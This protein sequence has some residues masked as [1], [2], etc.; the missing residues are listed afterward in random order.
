MSGI[1]VGIPW[2]CTACC[3]A[4]HP[5]CWCLSPEGSPKLVPCWILAREMG[6]VAVTPGHRVLPLVLPAQLLFQQIW[7]FLLDHA[8]HLLKWPCP[9]D[10][11]CTCSL[12][13]VSPS[14][15]RRCADLGAV[16]G[17]SFP[18]EGLCPVWAL[19][20]SSAP[21]GDLKHCLRVQPCTGLGVMGQTGG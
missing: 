9:C 12:P 3:V 20:E 11:A 17:H 5:E 8:R 16:L 2:K 4:T 6:R 15:K 19:P 21:A 18:W 10:V 13:V 1:L 7:A 14:V